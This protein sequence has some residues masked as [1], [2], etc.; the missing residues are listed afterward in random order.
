MQTMVQITKFNPGYLRNEEH[1]NLLTDLRELITVAIP[2][3]LHITGEY[4]AFTPL[5]AEEAIVMEIIS[6]YRKVVKMRK[7]R[8]GKRLRTCCGKRDGEA[9][10]PKKRIF[11]RNFTTNKK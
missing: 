4:A 2:F 9:G 10:T 6:E 8:S 3:A 11:S 7:S 1:F 5:L